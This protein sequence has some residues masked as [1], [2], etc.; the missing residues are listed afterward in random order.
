MKKSKKIVILTIIIALA[1]GFGAYFSYPNPFEIYQGIL[2]IVM[3][4][5]S[6]IIIISFLPNNKIFNPLKFIIELPVVLITL[7]LP[8]FT[9]TMHFLIGFV[10]PLGIISLIFDLIPN[11]ISG[12]NLNKEVS[13]YLILTIFSIYLVS[14]S[15]W[16]IKQWSKIEKNDK[17]E[18]RTTAELEL[19]K[20]FFGQERIRFVIYLLFL[21]ALVATS[22]T[23]LLNT[24]IFGN[25]N[26]D[27][28]VLKSF[29]TF[30]AYE[31]VVSN[32]GK[33]KINPKK[34]WHRFLV[35]YSNMPI[36]SRK[37]DEN[38]KIDK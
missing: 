10:I 13:L 31:R 27:K 11:E 24:S 9:T 20:S 15:E 2:A 3:G 28:A 12:Y 34:V 33:F 37:D 25:N 17:G 35:F 1:F 8:L 23:D 18:S 30:L 7:L 16:L 5:F 38:R 32:S 36:F 19:T 26:V 29:L 6:M 21:V 4:Y 22:L 14:F